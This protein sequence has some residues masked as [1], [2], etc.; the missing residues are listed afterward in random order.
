MRKLTLKISALPRLSSCLAALLLFGSTWL[1]AAQTNATQ[2]ELL[3]KVEALYQDIASKISDVPSIDVPSALGANAILL[4][5]RSAQERAVSMI[6]GA[7]TEAEFMRIY[8]AKPKLVVVYCTIGYRSGER[9]RELRAQGIDAR[10]LRGGI[11]AWIAHG[12]ALYDSLGKVTHQV[13]VYAKAWA[14]VPAN[15]SAVF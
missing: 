3:N 2:G 15:Y 11:L 14:V 9:A 12:G 7:V 13:H 5:V 1:L 6:P 10:N 4:D 8:Q